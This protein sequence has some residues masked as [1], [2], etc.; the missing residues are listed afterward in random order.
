MRGSRLVTTERVVCIAAP[1]SDEVVEQLSSVVT[2]SGLEFVAYEVGEAIEDQRVVAGDVLGVV[3]GGDGTFLRAVREFAPREIPILG[4]NAGTLAFLARIQPED[5]E[6]ALLEILDGRAD[7]TEQLQF[8]VT[9][10]GLDHTGINEVMFEPLEAG[11]GVLGTSR[12][13]VFVE[14]EYVGCYEGGGVAV[15]TPI[16]STAMALSAGGPVHVPADND[17]L[18]VT[19]LH[20]DTA[21]V[22]PL[23]VGEN[24]EITVVAGTPVHVTVDGGRPSLTAEAGTS[25]SISG[26]TT[27]VY[28]V[29]SSAGSSFTDALVDKLGWNVR[30]DG[31]PATAARAES[32]PVDT[33]SHASLTAR[34]AVVAAG[35]PVERL[36]DRLQGSESG[37]GNEELVAAAISRSERIVTAIIHNEFPNHVILSEGWRLRNG[38]SDREGGGG[39][40][41]DRD[42]A[43]TGAEQNPEEIG[44]PYT[45]VIDPIDGTGNFAHG[46]PSFTIALAL[47]DG[48]DPVVG[49]V[50][51][52]VTDELFH[53][54]KGHDAYRN[55]TPI[56]PTDRDTLAESMLLSGY[57]PTGEF[58]KLFYRQARGVRRL[59]SVSLHLCYVAAG[60]AD[61][62]WEYDTYFWDVAA[63][64]CILREAGGRA[65]DSRGNEYQLQL[66]DTGVRAPLLAS[67]GPLHGAVLEGLPD[68]G[69]ERE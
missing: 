27:P 2:D 41:R 21:T 13:D 66:D 33:L 57:D 38:Q 64:L 39:G 45:W 17:T 20:T 24:R 67:N 48:T 3:V 35:E 30:R 49:V 10:G 26:A 4:V 63:G 52:P 28:L 53:A 42:D 9:G 43:G 40:T 6:A 22:R 65:T 47:V 31:T 7:V 14:G 25:F 44:G 36:Y 8:H 60:S 54:A 18:Q 51:S 58:L 15:N 34:E 59:G 11:E 61:A 12:L 50:Y 56:E 69:F 62:Q 55:G 19:P 68:D 29:H 32:Q 46:N 5:I 37:G 16:G 23:V 1:D